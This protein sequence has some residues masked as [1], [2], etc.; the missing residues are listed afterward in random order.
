MLRG[1]TFETTLNSDPPVDDDSTIVVAIA[2]ARVLLR[3]KRLFA[4]PSE[5][6]AALRRH[7]H[8]EEEGLAAKTFE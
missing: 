4:V 6:G 5:S 1:S 7:C 3:R 8:C 2:I